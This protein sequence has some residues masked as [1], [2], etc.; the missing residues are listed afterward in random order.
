MI[1]ELF[2]AKEIIAANIDIKSNFFGFN[3]ISP[4]WAEEFNNEI[5]SCYMGLCL[6]SKKIKILFIRQNCTIW[7]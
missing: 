1:Q 4:V 3:N 5:S 2:F 6:Q 7:R